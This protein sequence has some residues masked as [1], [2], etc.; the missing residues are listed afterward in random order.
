[1]SQAKITL[2][3]LFALSR[4]IPTSMHPVP[5]PLANSDIQDQA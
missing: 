4:L 5:Y 2:P 1:M 3:R